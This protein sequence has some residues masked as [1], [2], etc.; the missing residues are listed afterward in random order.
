M[1]TIYFETLITGGGPNDVATIDSLDEEL[2]CFSEKNNSDWKK[3]APL[4]TGVGNCIFIST[5]IEDPC[6]LIYKI[7]E[8][9]EKTKVQK[10][11]FLLRMLPIAVT[12]KSTIPSILT[13][14]TDLF[15]KH[16]CTEPTTFAIVFNHRY[17]NSVS[18]AKLIVELVSKVVS[19]GQH[20]VDLSGEA[21]ITII[22][23]VLKSI[24]CLSV[25]QDYGHF[26][27]FNL[28]SVCGLPEKRTAES[29]NGKNESSSS[30]KIKE[31]EE[32]DQIN[33]KYKKQSETIKEILEN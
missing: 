29:E 30:L 20:T 14:Y 5:T 13:V 31:C 16:F 15:A 12:C 26:F 22:V 33:E 3:F 32:N 9:I 1:Q 17:N 23:E 6:S 27:K 21:K 18:R 2:Q 4:D 24:C 11:Q 28:H 19:L 8:D 10:T 25:V 7:F